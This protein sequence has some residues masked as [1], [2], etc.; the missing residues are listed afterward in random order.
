MLSAIALLGRRTKVP[1]HLNRAVAD[2]RCAEVAR[3]A[4]IASVVLQHQAKLVAAERERGG[5]AG[6]DRSVDARTVKCRASEPNSAGFIAQRGLQRAH[7]SAV[8]GV[9]HRQGVG[10]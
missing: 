5:F 9:E 2:L 6:A 1:A 8:I 3:S 10:P 4:E 7:A